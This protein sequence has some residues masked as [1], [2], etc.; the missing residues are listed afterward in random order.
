MMEFES[1][2]TPPDARTKFGYG[3]LIAVLVL[4]AAF[5]GKAGSSANADAAK[6]V[7]DTAPIY[8]I[9]IIPGYRDWRLISVAGNGEPST[10]AL[11]KLGNDLAIQAYR[12]GA[13]RFPDG[14]VLA[15]LSWSRTAAQAG[16]SAPTTIQFM[17]KDWRRYASTGGWGFAQ[18]TNGKP[19]DEAV[20]KTC[21][22]C[23]SS[24][25]N[26]DF[27]FSRYSR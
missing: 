2:P 17:V 10:E 11:A 12:N 1:E 5:G 27:V 19:D 13:Q 21:F 4:M 9:R 8:G 15:R 25:L 20:H 24:I 18:F 22:A 16:D 14:A 7:P 6:A 26:R 3:A 23:H